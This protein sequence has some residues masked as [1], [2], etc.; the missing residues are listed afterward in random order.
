MVGAALSETMV[1]GNMARMLRDIVGVSRE[2]IDSGGL[3]LPWIRI[4]NLHFS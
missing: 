3:L 2:R 4:A 1:S